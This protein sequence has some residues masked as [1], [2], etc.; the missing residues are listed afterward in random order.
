MSQNTPLRA[1][2]IGV[3]GRGCVLAQAINDH[4]LFNLAGLADLNSE[5]LQKSGDEL[6]VSASDQF[7][8]Y[9]DAIATGQ[10]DIAFCVASTTAHFAITSDLLQAGLHCLVE[11]PITLDLDQAR[12]LVELAK[13]KNRVLAVGQNYRFDSVRR[14]VAEVLQHKQLGDLSSVTGQ[15]YRQRPPRPQDVAIDYPLLFIQSIHHLDWILSLLPS[16]KVT[17]AIHGLPSWSP[18]TSPSVCHVQMKSG[19]V[20]ISYSGSYDAQGDITP[21]GGLWRF[22]C[23]RGDLLIDHDE[24]VWQITEQGEKKEKVF[25]PSKQDPTSEAVMLDTLY[26]GIIDGI[27]PPTSGRQNLA[28]LQ[29]IFDVIAAGEES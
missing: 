29:L 14:F 10:F 11:K 8:D 6:G 2:V 3:A 21:Y 26:A 4:P 23:E 13:Q 22:A 17:S 25:S 12:Q 15:F 24:T 28:T 9:H 7:G 27:E 19:D 18:W 16:A 1:L 20:V 5:L